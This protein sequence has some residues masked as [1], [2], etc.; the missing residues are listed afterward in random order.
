MRPNLLYIVSV[1]IMIGIGRPIS[2]IFLILTLFSENFNAYGRRIAGSPHL[3]PPPL[4]TPEEEIRAD[5]PTACPAAASAFW[6]IQMDKNP[7]ALRP[8]IQLIP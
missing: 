1:N 4:P 5:I 3:P 6:S 8:V 7:A 2:S